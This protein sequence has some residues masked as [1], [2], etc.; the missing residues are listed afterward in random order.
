MAIR[1]GNQE[2]T[3]VYLGSTEL[4]QVYLGTQPLLSTDDEAPIIGTL[5]YANVDYSSVEL[6]CSAT[7]NEG[8]TSF[9]VYDDGV[10]LTE[11]Q[12]S[13]LSGYVLDNLPS[14][15]SMLLSLKAKDSAGNL[16]DFSNTISF[17][18][19]QYS[20]DNYTDVLGLSE[21]L[22][23]VPTQNDSSWTK[24]EANIGKYIGMTGRLVVEAKRG[25]SFRGDTQIDDI[26]FSGNS[27]NPEVGTNDFERDADSAAIGKSYEAVRWESLPTSTTSG[28]WN[29]DGFGTPTSST[30]N[31]SGN[32]GSYYYYIETS[33]SSLGSNF[34][35]RS[36][37]ILIDE[38][39]LSLYTAQN[40]V[41]CG[42]INVYVDIEEVDYSLYPGPNVVNQEVT[43]KS[44]TDGSE[45]AYFI[46]IVKPSGIEIGDLLI[47]IVAEQSR[48][49]ISFTTPVG[50][51]EIYGASDFSFNRR[52]QTAYYRIADGTEGATLTVTGSNNLTSLLIG[53]YMV[54][55][56]HDELNPIGVISS[57]FSNSSADNVSSSTGSIPSITTTEVN[58]LV[59][60]SIIVG[61]ESAQPINYDSVGWTN[62]YS[63]PYSSSS[64]NLTLSTGVL[65]KD[66][67]GATGTLDYSFDVNSTS[68]A[69]GTGIM[70]S[71]NPA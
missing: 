33:G 63:K 5:S 50:W 36:P 60:S 59:L 9:E 41:D 22:I 64:G 18:T 43:L 42:D 66:T 49:S 52:C 58:S 3:K 46:D 45:D 62:I 24:R 68:R 30:G 15:T 34:W 14:N 23:E 69:W 8:V 55:K 17:S 48:G 12:E 57:G 35:L 19:L 47:V 21:A 20:Y 67:I 2:I 65:Y 1:I 51:T 28:R 40:G 16:S 25:S 11:I 61:N 53:D 37:S 10:L 71:I 4:S 6:T 70:F 54:I 26:I 39:T 32:T 27:Y 13:D 38:N 31:T 44:T 56:G 7:D 29:R